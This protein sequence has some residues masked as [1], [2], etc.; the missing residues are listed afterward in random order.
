MRQSGEVGMA[1]PWSD[2]GSLEE[3]AEVTC[4]GN[5]EGEATKT[6]WQ[7]GD[8]YYSITAEGLGGDEDFGLNADDLSSLINGIQ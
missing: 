2:V 5:R 4:F 8:Y 7:S 6:I 1:D 3:A